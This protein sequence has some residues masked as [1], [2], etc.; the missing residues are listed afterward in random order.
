MK[1]LIGYRVFRGFTDNNGNVIHKR[2]IG[3]AKTMQGA[4][5]LCVGGCGVGVD[6]MIIEEVYAE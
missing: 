5:A 2:P 1:K 4:R 3:F 6:K